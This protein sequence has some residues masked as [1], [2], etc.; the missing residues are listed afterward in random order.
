MAEVGQERY[1]DLKHN[2]FVH[3]MNL[4]GLS[5]TAELF[6]V[7]AIRYGIWN[8][9]EMSLRHSEFHEIPCSKSL[10]LFKGVKDF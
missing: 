3:Q 8:L 10:T 6:S 2:P 9:R 4:G 5:H 7:G 1:S